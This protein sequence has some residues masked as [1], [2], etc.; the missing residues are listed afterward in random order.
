MPTTQGSVIT[1]KELEPLEPAT[2]DARAG[3]Y[4]IQ[5]RFHVHL[6][7]HLAAALPSRAAPDGTTWPDSVPS[8]FSF[9]H[10]DGATVIAMCDV[11]RSATQKKDY[12]SEL[13]VTYEGHVCMWPKSEV[14]TT[15]AGAFYHS[16]VMASRFEHGTKSERV[17][18]SF[19]RDAAGKRLG[20][21][22]NSEGANRYVPQVR[23]VI[24]QNLTASDYGLMFFT[25]AA[26]TGCVNEDGWKDP[27]YGS[28]WP[29][30]LWLY[31]GAQSMENRD[32]TFT[33]Q[34]QFDYEEKFVDDGVSTTAG[35]A[36]YL[37]HRYAWFFEEEKRVVIG[38]VEKRQK[39]AVGPEQRST[40]Y[41]SSDIH[42]A[43][44]FADL[45][46]PGQFL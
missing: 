15:T 2:Y 20:I 18:V 17:T 36:E 21:G 40:I 9:V 8:G 28:I 37:R 41:E 34:H 13:T 30:G 25:I 16:G 23:W 6:P 43:H 3:M 45:F 46:A 4:Q 42:A 1:V 44:G 12:E 33:L 19:D 5:R 22:P 26:L 14:G 27:V 10:A 31:L 29:A 11:Q 7:W 35:A 39:R 32:G 38:G 24:T